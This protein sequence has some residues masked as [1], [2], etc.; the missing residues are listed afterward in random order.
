MAVSQDIVD[1]NKLGS[2]SVE[3]KELD[4]GSLD[5][6][7]RFAKQFNAERRQLD[8]LICN[9]GIMAPP[10]RSETVDG[11]EQQFQVHTA[12]PSHARWR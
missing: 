8:L 9:A 7:R 2:G 12:I 3:V 11:L 5:S 1:E 4:L 10:D 6:V